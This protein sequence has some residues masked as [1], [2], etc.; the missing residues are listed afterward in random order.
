M[1]AFWRS[2]TLCS[3]A[4]DAGRWI[5]VATAMLGLLGPTTEHAAT[6]K[7]IYKFGPGSGGLY[8]FGP[9]VIDSEGRLYGTTAG[10]QT[11]LSGGMAVTEYLQSV[12]FQLAPPEAAEASWRYTP[13]HIFEP[14]HFLTGGI[15]LNDHG[16]VFSTIGQGGT[17]GGGAVFKLERPEAGG[18]A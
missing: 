3:L 7:T 8:P 10:Y 15:T 17:E 4:R 2:F 11:T 14:G 1:H 18:Q 9:L 5:L 6:L 16:S 12:L 13:L